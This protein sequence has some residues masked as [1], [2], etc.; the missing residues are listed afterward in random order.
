[1]GHTYYMRYKKCSCFITI[2]ELSSSTLS[3]YIFTRKG[4][5]EEKY[6]AKIMLLRISKIHYNIAQCMCLC[7][8]YF[9]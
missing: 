9:R 8:F 3:T 6:L 7:L 1:M 5:E 2:K 4:P